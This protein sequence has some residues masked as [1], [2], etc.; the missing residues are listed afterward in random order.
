M[1]DQEVS[2]AKIEEE[3]ARSRNRVIGEAIASSRMQAQDLTTEVGIRTSLN[4]EL[5]A[6][7]IT[8]SQAQILL[9]QELQLRPLLAAAAVA[10][11]EA[12]QQ[13]LSIISQLRDGYAGMAEAQREASA[14]A[15]IRDQQSELETLRAEISLVGQ[16]EAVR[17]RSLALLQAEQTIRREGIATDSIR[18]QQIRANEASMA[19][20]RTELERTTDAWDRYRSAGEGAIDTIFDGLASGDFDFGQIARDLFSDLSKTYLELSV[21]N[22][23]KNA[24]FGTNYGT[25]DDLLNPSTA[26]GSA[27]GSNVG[28]MTVNAATVMINGGL[29]SGLGGFS[30]LAGNAANSGF[31]ANTTLGAF[32]G[33][34]DNRTGGY[35]GLGIG[36]VVT[37]GAN[38][39]TSSAVDLARPISAR[40]RPAT[41]PRSTRSCLPAESISMRHR[42]PGAP[43]S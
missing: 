5:A 13:L 18:A 40:R 19:D 41:R 9:E 23:L 1:A 35:S 7:N 17:R 22:P 4:A 38:R 27:L 33:A 21:K 2:S 34:N 6:G 29:A 30:S 31:Q 11:G 37:A 26:I 43:D 3:A 39:I 10:E 12:K 28:A 20:L 8:S 25:L 14:A 32:L 16:S 36:S 15:I 24:I 42:P